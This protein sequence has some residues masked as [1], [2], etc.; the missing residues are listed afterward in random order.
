MAALHKELEVIEKAHPSGVANRLFYFAIP[1]NVFLD[2]A[3]S[4]KATAVR[5][6]NR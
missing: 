3:A 2:T 1:P 4:I 6:Q 5:C